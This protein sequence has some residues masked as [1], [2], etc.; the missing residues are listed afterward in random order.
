[1]ESDIIYRSN[2]SVE[3]IQQVGSDAMVV[4]A[5]R[6]S[7]ADAISELSPWFPTGDA[8]L[9]SFL[10]RNRHASPFEHGSMTVLIEAPIF[11]AREWMRH[12]TMSYN[13]TSGRYRE[14]K[15]VF[16]VPGESRPMK[17]E[18]KPG[19][20]TFTSDGMLTLYAQDGIIDVTEHAWRSYQQLLERGVAKE[21]ARM[22]LPVNIYTQWYATANL[23]NW[24]NFL[25]LRTIDDNASVPSTPMYEI[26]N[27]AQQV[28]GL[29]AD[30]WP[31]SYNEWTN[32]GRTSL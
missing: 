16:Y 13:E 32:N 7:T 6:V 17:Q 25:S 27:A 4:A 10:M 26:E 28:E 1:M 11:V 19:D 20:Y 5:A 31:V 22:V 18:G 3:L 15:P 21:V 24:L 30:A 12:R 23:R 9:I 8:K 14:L 2:M 29:I